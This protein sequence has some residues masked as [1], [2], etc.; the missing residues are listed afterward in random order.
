MNC[1]ACDLRLGEYL[2]GGL[3]VY[4]LAHVERHLTQCAPCRA[5]LDELRAVEQVL[6]HASHAATLEPAP[7]FT[8]AVMGKARALARPHAQPMLRWAFLGWYLLGAWALIGA[9]ALAARPLLMGGVHALAG[10]GASVL[11]VSQ[12]LVAAVAVATGGHGAAIAAVVTVV[13][14][15]DALLALGV[16]LVHTRLELA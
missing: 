14:F 7:N 9:L 10:G 5:L 13:L 4:T 6:G 1:K 11:A 3:D 16:Y 8:P 15:A 2:E 12:A